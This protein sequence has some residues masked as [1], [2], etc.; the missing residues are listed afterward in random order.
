MPKALS[1]LGAAVS[2]LLLVLFGLDLMVGVPF[3]GASAVMDIAFL[4][5]SAL[6]GYLS[7]ITLRDVL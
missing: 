2:A 3:R 4:V 5:C 7:W 6:L 1:Y